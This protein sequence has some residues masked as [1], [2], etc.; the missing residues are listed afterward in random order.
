MR[1]ITDIRILNAFVAV[2]QEG[3]ISRAAKRLHLT[4][5]A[6]SLQLK[7][8]AEDTG[9][10]L[11]HRTSKGV[12]LTRDG[13]A[14]VAK[15]EKVQNAI[16]EFGQTARR[17]NGNVRGSLRLGTIVDPDFIRLGT[18]LAAL[19]DGY[20]DL[21]TKLVHGISG[22][23]INRLINDQLDVGFFLGELEEFEPKTE[24]QTGSLFYQRE[25]TKFTYRVIAPAGWRNRIQGKDWSELATMP[26]IGTPQNSVHQRLLTRIYGDLD[27]QPEPVC[28]VDQE[29]SM[30]AMV[31]SGIGLSL[32]RES[33]A[34]EEMQ[35][36]GLAV[37][38]RV[39]IET[40]LRFVTLS[41]KKKDPNVEAAFDALDSTW[42]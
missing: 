11:F 9:L 3:N 37:S 29:P 15:A 1:P 18:F 2:A 24:D 4:Q 12:E 21:Q 10:E 13:E 40:C 16:S 30:L 35:N 22:D 33:I 34:L 7:R 20:P 42:S 32:C 19:V 41:A 17:I 39:R 23:V 27:T 25:L 31:R 36:R 14:L 38:D 8:L 6:V 5:P 26:W 28:L